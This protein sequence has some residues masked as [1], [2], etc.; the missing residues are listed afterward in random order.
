VGNPKW[1]GAIFMTKKIVFSTV[2]FLFVT[3]FMLS[4]SGVFVVI[5]VDNGVSDSSATEG[6]GEVQI[7]AERL[8]M[9]R[10]ANES[11]NNI[12]NSFAVSGDRSE[13]DYGD[14][15]AGA[16]INDKGKLVVLIAGGEDNGVID[17]GSIQTESPEFQE[18]AVELLN[19]AQPEKSD[20]IL[21]QKAEHSYTYLE[22]LRSYVEGF[23][24]GSA[25]NPDSIW[26]Q[27]AYLAISDEKNCIEIGIVDLDDS[28]VQKFKSEV[29]DSDTFTFEN[30]GGF[31]VRESLCAG[32][33]LA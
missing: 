27:I 24:L 21:F 30:I 32:E 12:L 15:Y 16:Y 31:L 14:D 9:E 11:Y 29:L 22:E 1:K 13:L 33:Q 18:A 10:K 6:T 5:G 7:S 23:A 28:K 25:S 26:R 2:V 4:A 17:S 8:E 19:A 3:V 20:K